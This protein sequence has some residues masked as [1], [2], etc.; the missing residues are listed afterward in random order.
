MGAGGASSGTPTKAVL[1]NGLTVV[2]QE[3]HANPTVSISGALLSAGGVFDP[4]AKRGL[5]DFTASQLSRGTQKRSLLDIA[6]ALEDV[7]A[8]ADVSGGEEYATL[9]GRSLT[10]DFPLMLD[11]LVRRAAPPHV[12]RRRAGQGPRP[13]PWPALKKAAPRPACWPGSP[14]D[15]ALYPVGHPYY[16]PTLDQQAAFLKGLTRQDLVAF[17]D[18]HYAPDKMILTIVGDVNAQ[19]A[20]AQ[21]TKYFG[22]WQKKGNLPDVSIPAVTPT[23]RPGERSSSSP[24]RTRR[25]WTSAT[26]IP[27]GSRARTRTSTAWSS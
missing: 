7:G 13:G 10:K 27:A 25:R 15:D 17:H 6:A 18:A 22:D 23:G 8:S 3:N 26:A 24:S 12:P 16:S 11:V 19:D 20:V 2:V 9:E 14:F 1:P 5:A 21:V 4:P